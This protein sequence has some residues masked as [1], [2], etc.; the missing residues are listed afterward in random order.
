MEKKHSTYSNVLENMKNVAK[1]LHMTF[2]NRCEVAVHDFRDLEHSL[3]HIEGCITNRPIG[4]PITDLVVRALRKEGE[5]VRDIYN[6]P[7]TTR[8]GRTLK[9]S[10]CFARSR[11]GKVVGA[12]CINLETTDM[13]NAISMMQELINITAPQANTAHPDETFAH[14]VHETNESLM[15]DALDHIAKHPSTMT[16]EDRIRLVSLLD[17][18]GA[19]L[20][21]GMV[22][23]VAERLGVSKFTVYNYLKA[24]R[25][26]AQKTS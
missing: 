3:I 11:E 14:T 1:V 25:M 21:K 2:G 6:Y 16:R 17:D 15:Q 5:S 23:Y 20:I 12:L 24:A 10:T 26:D 22:D 8:D 13:E 18:Y 9:S 4:A 19:F 7:T